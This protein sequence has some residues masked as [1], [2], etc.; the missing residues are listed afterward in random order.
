MIFIQRN[1]QYFY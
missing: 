1:A